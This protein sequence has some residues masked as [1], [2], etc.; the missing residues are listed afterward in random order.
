MTDEEIKKLEDHYAECVCKDC[1]NKW[2]VFE[3]E[4]FN[5]TC[6]AACASENIGGGYLEDDS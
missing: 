5:F 1:G 3:T 6:C 2:N 4:H